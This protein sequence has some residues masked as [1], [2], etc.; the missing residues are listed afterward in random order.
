MTLARAG[1]IAPTDRYVASRRVS[2]HGTP[3]KVYRSLMFAEVT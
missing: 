3:R 2:C 1:V